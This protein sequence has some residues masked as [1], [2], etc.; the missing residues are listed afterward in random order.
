MLT[1]KERELSVQDFDVTL[2]EAIELEVPDKNQKVVI[3]VTKRHYYDTVKNK[4]ITD[5][6]VHRAKYRVG[7]KRKKKKGDTNA[8]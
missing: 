3:T 7:K 4:V 5:Q 2:K 1:T 8:R 6:V